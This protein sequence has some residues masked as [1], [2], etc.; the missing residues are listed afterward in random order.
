MSVRLWS[1]ILFSLSIVCC[2]FFF[3]SPPAVA[4]GSCWEGSPVAL[5][6]RLTAGQSVETSNTL[7]VTCRSDSVPVYFRVCISTQNGSDI[8]L[9]RDY[10]VGTI[11]FHLQTSGQR[12]SSNGAWFVGT[13]AL[14]QGSQ[15]TIDVP[16]IAIISG[17]DSRGAKGTY[18]DYSLPL[19]MSYTS[20]ADPNNLQECDSPGA[21][22]NTY[23]AI[24]AS[25]TVE[26]GCGISTTS[27]DFGNLTNNSGRISGS[28]TAT[29]IASCSAGISYNISLDY[30]QHASG[31]QRYACKDSSNCLRYNLLK[32]NG[33]LW[34]NT[35]NEVQGTSNSIGDNIHIVRGEVPAQPTPQG[36][37]YQDNINVT[38]S[39]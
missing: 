8:P 2:G 1:R 10:P 34:G 37:Q 28:T 9:K 15:T 14:S 12:N 32:E 39:Y 20:S 5:S 18:H 31:Q 23:N 4:G 35:S 21:I 17:V 36:G 29:L 24:S 11:N 7:H 13:G 25:A 27:M 16:I 30:G 33:T 19:A 22:K 26:E 6:F 3:F 38:I